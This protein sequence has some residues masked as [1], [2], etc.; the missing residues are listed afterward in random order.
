M[1]V[2]LVYR[3]KSRILP[4]NE[5]FRDMLEDIRRHAQ[6]YNDAHGLTGFL[7]YNNGYFYQAI[8]GD[9]GRVALLFSKIIRDD[10]HFDLQ[11]ISNAQIRTREFYNWS[12]GWSIDIVKGKTMDL[13][14]KFGLL[15]D[16]VGR[17]GMAKPI[18]RDIISRIASD[19]AESE[20]VAAHPA[21]PFGAPPPAFERM[22]R[23]AMNG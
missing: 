14:P 6:A 17:F 18:L 10:R 5:Q 13:G 22:P 20:R 23:S 9:F 12:M 16:Y 8:E 2:A 1:E 7:L 15:H 11:L 21:R 4:G 19:M 3:S